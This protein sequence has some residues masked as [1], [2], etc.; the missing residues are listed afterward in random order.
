[1]RISICS[2]HTLFL[3]GKKLICLF[4]LSQHIAISSFWFWN[5]FCLVKKSI[6]LLAILDLSHFL[7]CDL[8]SM[9]ECLLFNTGGVLI[10][11]YT[12]VQAVYSH[13]QK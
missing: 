2:L 3:W 5:N 10:S 11:L 8:I 9:Y 12:G 7:F 4:F 13:K 6:L 1:M